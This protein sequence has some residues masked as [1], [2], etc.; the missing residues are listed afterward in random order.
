MKGLV[1]WLTVGLVLACAF[2]CFYKLTYPDVQM[3]DEADNLG[4]LMESADAGHP[5][6]LQ[7]EGIPYFDK[8]HLW[9]ALTQ[10]AILLGG[11]NELAFRLVT[12]GA[13]FA[14][15]LLVIFT[16][17]RLFGP[18][19]ALAAGVFLLA[20]RQN[21]FFRPGHRFSTHHYRSADADTLMILFLFA[22]FA[23]LAA[24]V[25]GWRP[26][27]WL[28]A[29]ATGLGLLAKGPWALMPVAGFALFELVS[30]QRVQLPAK[31]LGL[32]ALAFSLVAVPWHL[33]MMWIWEEAFF[34][35]YIA[36]VYQRV[37]T[38]L[39]GHAPGPGYYL[40]VLGD[41][42]VF[43]GLELSCVAVVAVLLR[44]EKLA[45]FERSGTL[46]TLFC[47][48]AALQGSKTKI[49]WYVLPLYP[50]LALLVAALVADLEAWAARRP[51]LAAGGLAL[52]FAAM[53]P[54]AAFNAYSLL[55]LPR[56]PAQRFYAEVQERCRGEE[57]VYADTRDSAPIHYLA[58]RYGMRPGA[59][60]TATCTVA[61]VD[62][63]LPA[64][65]T[66][67]YREVVRGAGYVLWRRNQQATTRPARRSHS[68]RRG[69]RG[70]PSASATARAYTSSCP[71]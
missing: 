6:Q 3:W 61:R 24:R 18:W 11:R 17:G 45:R 52:V 48:A 46:L 31:E 36:Y 40:T 10:T 34:H 16:A 55:R 54:F 66:S 69:R 37:T 62:T 63:P 64:G 67:T 15:L 60:G 26:G 41:R 65:F 44:R 19:P 5:F 12:A 42:A 51:R 21:F 53:A 9:Y 2:F 56:G 14:L 25:R 30:P 28:A 33:A 50:F 43:F 4:V 71:P 23:C 35:Q 59:A 13:A 20:V 1:R 49:A 68:S 39:S 27:L 29:V 32:A 22:A 7:R 47:L 58:L 70:R 57:V 38:G 8:P